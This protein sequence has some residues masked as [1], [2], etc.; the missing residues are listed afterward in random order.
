MRAGNYSRDGFRPGEMKGLTG[1]LP[2]SGNSRL[3]TIR[4]NEYYRTG[5]EQT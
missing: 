4:Y 5:R 1:D 3:D 2:G